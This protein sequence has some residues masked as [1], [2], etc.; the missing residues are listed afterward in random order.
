MKMA[1]DENTNTV[2]GTFSKTRKRYPT[3]YSYSDTVFAYEWILQKKEPG[4]F[5]YIKKMIQKYGVWE[6]FAMPGKKPYRVK[7]WYRGRYRYWIIMNILA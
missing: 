3:P 4:L 2:S 5:Q 1:V 6:D 7:Y